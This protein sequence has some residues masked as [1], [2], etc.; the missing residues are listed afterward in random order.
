MNEVPLGFPLRGSSSRIGP[1]LPRRCGGGRQ[2]L[3][4]SAVA[5]WPLPEKG[6]L[7]PRSF[8][9]QGLGLTLNHSSLPRP[10][11][12]ELHSNSAGERWPLKEN[13][14]LL[15]E[16]EMGAEQTD[17]WIVSHRPVP[18]LVTESLLTT[19]FC[20]G[21]A[22]AGVRVRQGPRPDVAMM[23][24]PMPPASLPTGCRL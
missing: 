4:T 1:V 14:A 9:H 23:P 20:L 21:C 19:L 13:R 15:P 2:L 3:Q 7:I 12:G 22:G 6:G 8:S 16:G 10:T 11:F 17:K 18:W 5:A 24:S